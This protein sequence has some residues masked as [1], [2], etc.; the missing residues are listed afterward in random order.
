MQEHSNINSANGRFFTQ[1]PGHDPARDKK[2][3]AAVLAY[4]RSLPKNLGDRELPSQ[5]EL[6][7]ALKQ[8]RPFN[9]VNY[10]LL[11]KF[12]GR[13]Y[14]FERVYLGYGQYRFRLYEPNRPGYPK[15]KQQTV[16]NLS[17]D[18]KQTGRERPAGETRDTRAAWFEETFGKPKPSAGTTDSTTI[19]LPLFDG[20]KQ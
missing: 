19:E 4:Y 1:R 20:G 16:L 5:N 8:E 17:G 12:D 7:Q 11:G 9:R 2:G 6:R 15:H 13:C 18:E 3:C 10:L 14:D